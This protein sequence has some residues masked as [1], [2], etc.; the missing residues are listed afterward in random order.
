LLVPYFHVVFTVP[1]RLGAIAYQNNAVD[2]D[3]LFKAPAETMLTIAA[4]P[5]RLG[6][7][8]GITSVLHSWGSALVH[9]PHIHTIVP[10]GGF[11]LNGERL[12]SCRPRFLLP[13]RVLSWMCEHSYIGEMP[14]RSANPIRTAMVAPCSLCRAR[15]MALRPLRER[16]QPAKVAALIARARRWR[17]R[18]VPAPSRPGRC[19]M[20]RYA[21][22]P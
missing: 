16:P 12:V 22:P 4:D 13:V 7:L 19:A 14:F 9:H 1:A 15:K 2:Y 5:K 3:L 21:R 20:R 18:Q 17:G 11:S 6:V 10:G 8:I